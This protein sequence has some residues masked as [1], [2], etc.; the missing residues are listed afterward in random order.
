MDRDSPKTEFVIQMRPSRFYIGKIIDKKNWHYAA[1][2]KLDEA[3]RFVSRQQAQ[4]FLDHESQGEMFI[5]KF[6]ERLRS[7]IDVEI[8]ERKVK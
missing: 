8:V 7:I 5:I 3:H 6:T 1:T 4:Q 2:S